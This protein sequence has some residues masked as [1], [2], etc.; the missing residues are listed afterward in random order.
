VEDV[1]PSD[2]VSSV[3]LV[4]IRRL[5]EGVEVEAKKG[6]KE[7]ETEGNVGKENKRGRWML[8]CF[9]APP[10]FLVRLSF[11]YLPVISLLFGHRYLWCEYMSL[12]FITFPN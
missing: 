9:V 3:E 12:Q 5:K 2:N 1:P 11:F 4:G 8:S 7:M 10:G 6:S